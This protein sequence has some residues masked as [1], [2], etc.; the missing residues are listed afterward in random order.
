MRRFL[1]K[2]NMN[3]VKMIQIKA[4]GD[5]KIEVLGVPFGGPDRRDGDGEYFDATT[6]LHL[7]KFPAPPAVYYHGY[8]DNKT[9]M[10][11]PAY[12]GKTVSIE[13][14]SDGVWYRIVLD[15][16]SQ[17][18]RKVWLAAKEGLAFASSGSLL[19]LVRKDRDGHIAEW[20]VAELSLVDEGEGRR[21][22]SR[23]AIA[24]PV[25]KSIYK[26]AGET[27][28][29]GLEDF[30]QEDIA[31]GESDRVIILETNNYIIT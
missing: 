25:L 18:A 6:E 9:A 10:Q 20:P 1:F 17:Y 31:R 21:M 15:K 5:W 16:A 12:I 26:Q 29:D 11:K 28:P 14:R 24:L 8:A 2:E 22:A 23:D 4:L 19:H 3:A 30:S 27:L 13:K 7:D